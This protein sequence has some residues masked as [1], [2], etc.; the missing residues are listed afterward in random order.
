MALDQKDTWHRVEATIDS[1]S[2]VS[3]VP[4]ACVIDPSGIKV[5]T[6]GVMSYKSASEH[7]C[8]VVGGIRPDCCFQN[9]VEGAVDFKVLEPLK[10]I[11]ISTAKLRKAGYR[12]VHDDVSYIEHKATGNKIKMYERNGVYVIIMWMKGVCA[13]SN[14][15][16]SGQA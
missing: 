5:L 8:K 6:E 9:G 7:S 14:S 10:K 16:F 13:P 4:K 2:S 3:G 12:I 1:G 15:V 11:I